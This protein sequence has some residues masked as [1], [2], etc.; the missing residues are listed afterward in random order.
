[1]LRNTNHVI[2][3]NHFW[4]KKDN[5]IKCNIS[6][7]WRSKAYH[8]KQDALKKAKEIIKKIEKN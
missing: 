6:T 8:K 4:L 2:E 3:I 5:G 1:M 7:L